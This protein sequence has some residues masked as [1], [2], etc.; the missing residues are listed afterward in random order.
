[1][2]VGP[3]LSDFS[4]NS[5]KWI[6]F[7]GKQNK[8]VLSNSCIVKPEQSWNTQPERESGTQFF[9]PVYL[10]FYQAENQSS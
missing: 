1:M 10:F 3:E 9:R 7:R 4:A 5:A 6:I 2:F 8:M